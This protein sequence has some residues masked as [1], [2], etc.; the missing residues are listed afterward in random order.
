VAFWQRIDKWAAKRDVK[1]LVNA[2][3]HA[4]WLCRKRAAAALGTIADPNSVDPLVSLLRRETDPQVRDAARSAVARMVENPAVVPEARDRARMALKETAPPARAPE[5]SETRAAKDVPL[6][7]PGSSHELVFANELC[8][9]CGA[10]LR[11]CR[12]CRGGF[13]QSAVCNTFP[14]PGGSCRGA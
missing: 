5:A 7:D 3:E 9:D 11:E 8:H 13:H 2:L 14:T 10:P 4:D 6:W 1:N 12:K